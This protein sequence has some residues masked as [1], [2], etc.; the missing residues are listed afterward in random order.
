VQYG[1]CG[2]EK[3]LNVLKVLKVKD[4]IVYLKK[5]FNISNKILRKILI[6]YNCNL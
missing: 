1:L 4:L 5:K 2:L 6:N 3:D